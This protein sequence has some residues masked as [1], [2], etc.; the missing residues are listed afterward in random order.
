MSN[1]TSPSVKSRAEPNRF[2]AAPR[3][4]S[5]RTRGGKAAIRKD[6]GIPEKV[7]V[8]YRALAMLA[9]TVSLV[10]GMFALL[11]ANSSPLSDTQKLEQSVSTATQTA[12]ANPASSAPAATSSAAPADINVCVFNAGKQAGL[13]AKVVNSLKE[14]KFKVDGNAQNYSSAPARSTVYYPPKYQEEAKRISKVVDD[15]TTAER[16]GSLTVCA[17]H[18]VVVL[19]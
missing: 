1:P 6:G 17:N 3:V 11:K 13:G 7:Y 5:D 4:R 19:T 15:S 14:A 12:A 16:P 9:F 10:L 2:N 8:P 18:I